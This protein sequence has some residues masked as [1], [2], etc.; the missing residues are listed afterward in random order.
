M[1]GALYMSDLPSS[2]ERCGNKGSKSLAQFCLAQF[3]HITS[4]WLNFWHH[5]YQ[6]RHTSL[7][8]IRKITEHWKLRMATRP[9]IVTESGSS[10][11]CHSDF[12]KSSS[13]TGKL[14]YTHSFFECFLPLFIHSVTWRSLKTFSFFC[15][16]LTWALFGFPFIIHKTRMLRLVSSLLPNVTCGLLLSSTLWKNLFLLDH[17]VIRVHFF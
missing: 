11:S 6:L 7:A 3:C 17:T 5:L 12:G 1:L 15:H 4:V 2:S 9:S 10:Q 16:C 8:T 14:F 13:S